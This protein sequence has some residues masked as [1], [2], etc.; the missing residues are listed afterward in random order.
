M[1]GVVINVHGQGATV[2]LDDGTLASVPFAELAAHR[3]VYVASLR[4]RTA[5]DLALERAGRHSV[6]FLAASA[7]RGSVGDGSV[8]AAT[9]ADDGADDDG[10]DGAIVRTLRLVG[11]A[12]SADAL[13]EHR[14]T[15]YLKSTEAWAP[16][17]QPA[18]D[19]RHQ[20]RKK[21]R[22]AFFESRPPKRPTS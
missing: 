6:V 20:V 5:L 12:P 10:E 17:D 22:A 18:P 14:M 8:A 11:E 19:E 4:E 13:F 9:Q 3:P 2:R 7:L 1:R 15:A 16:R 21:R